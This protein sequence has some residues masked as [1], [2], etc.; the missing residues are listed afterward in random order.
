M[1]SNL[2]N[3][4]A[5][6]ALAAL[7]NSQT[8]Y[9]LA[10]HISNPNVLDPSP[11]ELA[12][13]GYVRQIIKFAVPSSRS[14]VSNDAQNYSGLPAATIPYLGVWTTVAG[15]FLVFDIDTSSNPL[16]SLASGFLY[17]MPGD[18]ALSF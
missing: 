4:G 14:C 18:V 5:N 2:G 13:G 9:Y 10:L 15:G 17:V 16:V 12:G 7:L 11:T 6:L 3:Y 1:T 8:Q